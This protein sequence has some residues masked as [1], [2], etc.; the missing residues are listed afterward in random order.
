[1]NSGTEANL[2]ALSAA[3]AFTGRDRVLAF[4][5]GYHGGLLTFTAGASPVNA[6]YDVLLAEYNDPAAA[7]A[8]LREHAGTVACV[9]VEPMLGAGGGI[10]R[11]PAV[12]S[13]PRGAARQ[14]RAAPLFDQ[15]MTAPTGAPGPPPPACA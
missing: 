8:L 1:T 13:A 4:R 6:P 2:M 9:L 11:D 3:R 7:Q 14:T 12:P 15:V 10:P 5:G